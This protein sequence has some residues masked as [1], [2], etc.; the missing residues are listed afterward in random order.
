[1]PAA[2]RPWRRSTLP[3][4]ARVLDYCAGGG[5]KTLALAARTEGAWFAHDASARRMAD[6]PG[7]AARAGVAVR[8]CDTGELPGLAPFDAV[9]CDV[10]CSGS[11]TWRRAPQAK[12]AL[13]PERLAELVRT[14]IGIL[15]RAADL[16]ARDGLLVYCTCSV[17][18]EENEKVIE[19]FSSRFRDWQVVF[20]R[21]W[22]ISA[23]GDGFFI[24]Q[25]ERENY[26]NMQS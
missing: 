16:V 4:G 10:P 3:Q 6:L 15:A 21:R 19:R 26:G 1:M 22:P 12:W 7:R 9:V 14:Q 23:V 24:A 17:L 20:A 25:L 11:G 8:R 18:S 5:G 13:T 2:R